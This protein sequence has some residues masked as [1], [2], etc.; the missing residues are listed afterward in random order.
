[1]LARATAMSKAPQSAA[2]AVSP[3]RPPRSA[4]PMAPRAQPRRQSH[5]LQTPVGEAAQN[6]HLGLSPPVAAIRAFSREATGLGALA[7]A[8]RIGAPVHLAIGAL[9]RESQSSDS[10]LFPVQADTFPA[11]AKTNP[12]SGLSRESG[13]STLKS[14]HQLTPASAAMT[15]KMQN[16]LLFSLFSG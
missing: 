16:S 12:C 4:C 2:L 9:D 6:A 10:L 8:E 3:A 5:Q 15:G 14:L 13:C 11:R 1:M 7:A